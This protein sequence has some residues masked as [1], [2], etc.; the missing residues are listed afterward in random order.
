MI[1]RISISL[2]FQLIIFALYAPLKAVCFEP[3]SKEEHRTE[4]QDSLGGLSIR[5]STC[6][7]NHDSTICGCPGER[8]FPHV[9]LGR[10]A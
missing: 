6:F 3:S 5:L 4:L 8:L 9:Q 2:G 7:R 1:G 10:G